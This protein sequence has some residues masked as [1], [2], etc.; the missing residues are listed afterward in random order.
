MIVVLILFSMPAFSQTIITNGGGSS[1]ETQSQFK[2]VSDNTEQKQTWTQALEDADKALIMLHFLTKNEVY[3]KLAMSLKTSAY[4]IKDEKHEDEAHGI[5]YAQTFVDG[6][7]SI[8]VQLASPTDVYTN[9]FSSDKAPKFKRN[10]AIH[11][12]LHRV[13][14]AYTEEQIDVMQE[15]MAKTLK[16]SLDA[17]QPLLKLAREQ[18]RVHPLV[19]DLLRLLDWAGTCEVVESEDVSLKGA[20]GVCR[21]KFEHWKDPLNSALWGDAQVTFRIIG[22][23]ENTFTVKSLSNLWRGEEVKETHEID[24]R[25]VILQ[26]ELRDCD[27]DFWL[28]SAFISGENEFLGKQKSL[29]RFNEKTAFEAYLP[30]D[31]L[32]SQ[33]TYFTMTVPCTLKNFGGKPLI[34]KLR[35]VPIKH[36]KEPIIFPQTS[37]KN[38]ESSK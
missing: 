36:Q 17:Y 5:L 12:A 13:F 18:N 33:D 38:E 27:N 14:P 4:T 3:L 32:T 2:V 26:T 35:L 25:Q 28:G 34:L 31:I 30:L 6:N 19:Y 10:L 7:A 15:E 9:T 22:F 11:E 20:K 16:T 23:L 24:S 21:L 1:V 29:Q 8:E 37:P